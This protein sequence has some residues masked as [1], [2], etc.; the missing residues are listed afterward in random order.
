M[1][2]SRFKMMGVVGAA[3][4]AMLATL[5]L[6][7][8][9]SAKLTGGY[10]R[11]EFCP[12]KNLEVARCTV[13][14]TEGGEV[15]LGSK[16]VPIVNEVTLQGGLSKQSEGFAKFFEAT[17]GETL[18]K[19]PQPVP[20]GLLG[21]VPP[22]N[23]PPL[24]KALVEL[25]AE[26]GLTGV[27][28]TLEL[29]RPASEIK[30]SESNLGEA[31]GVALFLPIKAKLENPLLGTN[32]YVG[33]ATNPIIWELTSGETSPPPPAEPLLGAP[34]EVEFFEGGLILKLSNAKLVDNDW[35]APK[36]SG[37]GGPLLSALI[38]PVINLAA[39]LPAAAGVNEA[40]LENT[41]FVAT[42]NAV[43]KNDE[44]NP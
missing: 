18:E 38:D 31:E 30:I 37:C 3:V 32:C 6:A 19:V 21:L 13:A 43:R 34:G 24:I 23:S 5:A 40:I 28:S 20:G 9:A 42:G 10:T 27:N 4:L 16:T 22:E 25:A 39:G 29:A 35:A 17:N 44:L 11:F 12:F 1:T 8:T 36:A 33:S 14:H 41:L 15:T 7:S 2:R 26:N